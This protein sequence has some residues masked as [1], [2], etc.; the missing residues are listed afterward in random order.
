M[1]DSVN[2]IE[3]KPVGHV[4]AS[5]T[6][7]ATEIVTE[8]VAGVVSATTEESR[9]PDMVPTNTEEPEKTAEEQKVEENQSLSQEPIEE[10]KDKENEENEENKEKNAL[11]SLFEKYAKE[12]PTETITVLTDLEV[13]FVLK[14]VNKCPEIVDTIYKTLQEILVD[15]QINSKDI[16][17]VITLIK[18]TYD[19]VYR[20]NL[21]KMNL[22]KRCDITGK[23]LKFAIRVFIIEN[24][25]IDNEKQ[26]ELVLRVNELIDTSVSMLTFTQSYTFKTRGCFC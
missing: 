5:N 2:E 16:P 25:K 14:F 1:S 13:A 22:Y 23:F 17:S 15:G 6:E 24:L 19:M 8:I 21:M 9:E 10:N 7:I 18:V 20:T 12:K 4:D 11:L 26:T 3:E